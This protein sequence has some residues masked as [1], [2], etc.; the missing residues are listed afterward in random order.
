M[1]SMTGYGIEY[2]FVRGRHIVCW[3]KSLN[4]RFLEVY[5]NLPAEFISLEPR[6]RS[7]IKRRVKR[8]KIEVNMKI[9]KKRG[10]LP[11]LFYSIF[12]LSQGNEEDDIM[13]I[14]LSALY[15]FEES[16]EKEGDFIKDE[17][18]RRIENLKLIVSEIQELH[19]SFPERIREVLRERALQIFDELD[20]GEKSKDVL[21]KSNII[22][23][24]GV[25]HIIRK[26]DISEEISRVSIH[27]SN[28]ED[29]LSKEGDGK[30]LMFIA[31]EI[32][33]E[34]NT[35]GTKTLDIRISEKVI[36][37]KLEVERIREQLYNVE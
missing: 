32:L 30:K 33:R 18:F 1:K 14:F 37:A 22:D 2:G 36:E 4:H 21:Q 15:K 35:M 13:N 5:F 10:F 11:S 9:E 20:M 29:E 27:F 3:I 24:A 23:E 16:R 17:L 6:M 34:F 8:G 26:S 19:K 12:N 7:E 31:Q 25:I 28:F